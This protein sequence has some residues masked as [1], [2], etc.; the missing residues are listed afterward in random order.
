M[1]KRRQAFT[2][3]EL[4]VVI[5]I[6]ALLISILLPALGKARQSAQTVTCLSQLRQFATVDFMYSNDNAG[7]LFPSYWQNGGVYVQS[8]LSNYIKLSTN[9]QNGATGTFSQR[10]YVCPVV[11]VD[12]TL[13]FPMTYGCNEGLHPNEQPS[14]NGGNYFY[15]DQHNNYIDLPIR[16]SQIRR[17]SEQI[18]MA[19]CSLGAGAVGGVAYKS[20]GWFYNTFGSYPLLANP[21]Y[22]GVPITNPG[23]GI[24]GE[25][26]SNTDLN[27]NYAVRFRH[28]QSN[29]CNA[30][31]ADGH[32]A[33]FHL[34]G[35]P[36]KSP[37][38]QNSDMLAKNF[39]TFY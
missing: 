3:V 6:I 27:G 30:V 4:L 1:S 11:S 39:A 38:G 21:T 12:S 18:S 29:A 26:W 9:E 10:L 22:A 35:S 13:Q 24:G 20:A 7:Y 28:G 25:S 32:A 2:L 16:R 36:S 33:T 14:P 15:I 17:A 31:F 23:S 34:S 5:G 19:D 8:I 37:V